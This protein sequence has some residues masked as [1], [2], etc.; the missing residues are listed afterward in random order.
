MK[1]I[2]R[3]FGLII[4][5]ANAIFT[6]F[7]FYKIIMYGRVILYEPVKSI[8]YSEFIFVTFGLVYAFLLLKGEIKYETKK[9]SR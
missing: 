4:L 9:I 2:I 3:M 7:V 8:L 1:R 6:F 5:I